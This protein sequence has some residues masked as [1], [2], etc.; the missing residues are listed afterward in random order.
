M[1]GDPAT[2]QL[3]VSFR[4]F[5]FM[6][7]H[8][9]GDTRDALT[10][11]ITNAVD[12][13][14]AVDPNGTLEK[15][16]NVTFHR[17]PNLSGNF[18]FYLQVVDN[19]IGVPAE[20]MKSCFLTAGSKTSSDNAR[21]F[22]S[23][24]AKNITVLGDTHFVSVSGNKL[25]KVYLDDVAYGHIVT[26][27]PLSD[28]PT[29]VPEVIGIDITQQQRD[30]LG[31]QEN[32]MNV[33]LQYTNTGEMDKFNSL[34]SIHDMLKGISKIATMRD[35]FA[36]PTYH[37]TID[38]NSCKP[39][40][41][42]ID[43]NTYDPPTDSDNFGG[44]YKQRLT[45][46]YP[47]ASLLLSTTFTV[48]NYEHYQGK[49][50]MYKSSTPI[51][52]PMVDN[53]LEFGFLI[54]DD[55]AIHEVNTLGL[56]ERY[57]WNPN[58][59]YIYGHVYCD[60]FNKELKRY[61]AGETTDLIIDPNRIGGINHAHPL[62]ISILSV[63]LPRLDQA[64][65]DVQNST[66]SRSINIDELDTIVDKLEDMGI[67]IFDDNV[68][69]FNFIPNKES[70]TIVAMKATEDN[71]VREISGE[72]N[73]KNL[74]PEEYIIEEIQSKSLTSADFNTEY[75]YYLNEQQEVVSQEVPLESDNEKFLQ[76]VVDQ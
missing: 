8:A 1:S 49:F 59:N 50:V 30:A 48:P 60:G 28:D 45:Y 23:T 64:L 29:I 39:H 41:S 38:I 12:A 10:E 61:D 62:Y 16:I 68:I 58:I 46:E 13:Y 65:L 15:Y 19:A 36:D 14:R 71:I 20:K 4:N 7:G 37:I 27:G 73:I 43:L 2:V 54:K 51:A 11:L 33:I 74:V 18:D 35:T 6:R 3:E 24:G 76:S 67:S 21:G 53:Q 25:S 22:F 56:N 17:V 72:S 57:R 9:V 44:I 75:I 5:L 47:N 40:V 63:C 32:G 55:V 31:I 26:H 70:D 66:V 69:Q 42:I 52:Q 34:Q